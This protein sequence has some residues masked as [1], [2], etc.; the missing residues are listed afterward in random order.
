[1]GRFEHLSVFLKQKRLDSG[2]SRTEL[3]ESLG[4]VHSQ[5]VTNWELGL[6]A[7]PNHKLDKLIT[8]LKIDRAELVDIMLKD[9]LVEIEEK[10]APP[11]KK[12]SSA[13]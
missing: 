9:S 1:M 4:K 3:A 8:V 13:G 5:F 6:C 2:L 12:S 10:L 11:K 7:P